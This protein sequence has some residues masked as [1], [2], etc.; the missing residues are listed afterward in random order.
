MA[1][2]SQAPLFS[3]LSK[4][5]LRR[6]AEVSGVASFKEGREIVKEGVSGSVFFVL[7]E[8][9]AKVTK[10]GRK[11]ARLGPGDFFG[12]MSVIVGTPRTASIVSE[13]PLACVTL[14]AKA[15]KEILAEEPGLAMKLLMHVTRR[16]V[17]AERP[18]VG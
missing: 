14:S 18:L 7:L 13:T 17:E 9:Q 5:H 11:V 3:G 6:I 4:R 1:A 2:L 10:G 15:L 16:L 12:E 8:G